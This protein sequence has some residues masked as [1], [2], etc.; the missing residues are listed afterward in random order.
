MTQGRDTYSFSKR[1]SSMICKF[2]R[3]FYSIQGR[4]YS[5]D[6]SD[7]LL[8]K[9]RRHFE[10]IFVLFQFKKLQFWFILSSLAG[11]ATVA[12]TYDLRLK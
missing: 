10:L 6:L 8:H 5:K 11:W 9:C 1:E 3:N 7:I 12:V 2:K 4:Q